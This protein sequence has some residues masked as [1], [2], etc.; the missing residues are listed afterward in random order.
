MKKF[1]AL[2]FLFLI[3]IISTS[4]N[5][6]EDDEHELIVFAASSLSESL[7][8]IKEVYE[9]ENDTNIVF[10]FDSS[11]TLK[12]QIQEG[13]E[14]DLFISASQKPMDDLECIDDNSRFDLIENKV[15]LVVSDEASDINSFE[16]LFTKLNNK[17]ISMSI[18]NEDVPVGE[19]TNLIFDYYNFDLESFSN[20]GLI[21]YCSSAK[22]VVSHVSEG[23]VDCAI[24]YQTDA[25]QEELNIVAVA[26]EEMCSKVRYP[27]AMINKSENYDEGLRFLSFLKDEKAS[28][29]FTKYGFTF[30]PE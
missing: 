12:K 10:N 29:V 16:D 1:L 5:T 4:C 22:E 2:L 15:V 13:A 26:T 27:A 3:T 24:V 28:G 18:G 30:L 20:T 7:N 21:T 23:L 9:C 25:V 11:G 14:C 17:E 8:E 19:Y 6:N